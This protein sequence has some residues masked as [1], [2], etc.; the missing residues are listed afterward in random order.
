MA[1]AAMACQVS[2][3]F[4]GTGCQSNCNPPGFQGCSDNQASATH[5]RIGYYEGW[6]LQTSSR[7][8]NAYT[9]EQISAETL[10]HINFAFALI[11]NSFTIIEMTPGDVQLW[12]RTTALKKKNPS[13]KVFLSIGGWSFNDPPT[14]NI[15]SDLVASAANRATFIS[16]ALSVLQAYAFDGIDVDWEYPAAYDRGGNPADKANFVTFMAEVKA[17]FRSNNYGLTFTA[18]SSYWYLQHFDLP[19]L[20]QHADW[21]NIMTYDLHGTWDGKDP[22]IGAIVQAHTNL[23]EIKQTMQLFANVG[24]NPSQMVMGIG[25]YGR[26]FQLADPSCN[27]PGCPFVSGAAPGVCSL[28]SGTLMFSE[29]ESIISSNALTPVFDSIDAV[30]YIVWNDNQWVSYDDSETLQMKLNYANSICLG[31]TM[32]WSVDQDDTS[33][34]ALKGLYP[35]INVN[36]PSFVDATSCMITGCGQGCPSGQQWSAMTTLTTNPGSSVTCP[37]NNPATLCCP[38][39]DKPRNCKWSGGGGTTCNAQCEVGQV[40][41]AIDPVG[42]GK[43]PTCLQGEKAYCCDSNQDLD[44]FA[45]GCGRSLNCA[46]GY[47]ALTTVKQ[48]SSDNGGCEQ[49]NQNLPHPQTCPEVCSTNNKPVCCNNNPGYK[50]C[51]WYG[52][53]PSCTHSACPAGQLA[54]FSD[55]QGD[56]SSPCLGKGKRLFCCDPPNAN[57]FLPVPEDWVFPKFVPGHSEPVNFQP[58]TFTVDF[59]QDTGSDTPPPA[60]SFNDGDENDSPFGEVFISSPNAASVSS[61]DFASDWVVTS[62]DPSSDQPQQVLAYC[63]LPLDH[64]DSGCGHVFIG[65]AKHTIVRMPK[66]CGVGPYARV[67]SLDVHSD[68]NILPDHHAARLPAGEKVYSLSFDYNF[69]A[70]PDENGPVL[71]R[72]DITNMQDYWNEMINS[73]PDSGTDTTRRRRDMK[74]NF[75]Q[76]H[77]YEKRWFGSF[78]SWLNRMNTVK[79]Q[80]SIARTFSWADSY[81]IFHQEESCPNFHSSLDITVAGNAHL[82]SH[83]GYYLEATVVPPA[84][85]QSYVYFSTGAGAQATFTITGLAGVNFDSDKLEVFSAGFPGLYY[86]GLLTL[87]P[88]LHVYVQLTGQLSMSGKFETSI[89]YTFPS[90]DVTIGKEDN[91]A[92]SETFEP[93]V[94]PTSSNQGYNFGFGYNVALEGSAEAHVIPTLQLGLSIL[95]GEL[96][97]AQ[98]FAEADMYVGVGVNGSVSNANAASFCVQPYYGVGVNGG[99]TGSLLWWRDNAVS[100]SFYANKFNFGGHCFSSVTEVDDSASVTKREELHYAEHW[101][102]LSSG[103]PIPILHRSESV[104]YTALESANGSISNIY[105][106]P[107]RERSL[108]PRA[109]VPFLPGNLFCPQDNTGIQGTTDGSDCLFYDDANADFNMGLLTRR[110]LEFNAES[111]LGSTGNNSDS[112]LHFK[113]LDRNPVLTTCPGVTINVPDYNQCPI[114]AYYDLENPTTLDP[115]F[116]S[117]VPKVPV[118]LGTNA[119]GT[120]SLAHP[121]STAIYS[122]EHPYEAQM[123]ATFIDFLQKSTGLWRNAAGNN[124]WCT[125]VNDNLRTTPNYMPAGQNVFTQIGQCYPSNANP[126]AMP[127][128]EQAANV[129]KN[130]ALF[131]GEASLMNANPI[132]VRSLTSFRRYC[133]Q[134]QISVMRATAGVTSFMND[135]TVKN[136][137]LDQNTCIKNVWTTWYGLY[138]TSNVDAPSKNNFDMA[139]LYNTWVFHVVNGVQP[140]LTQQLQT[141]AAN[142]NSANNGAVATVALS[143][144]ILLDQRQTNRNGNPVNVLQYVTPQ[145]QVTQQDV[146]NQ[147]VNSV[148]PIYWASDLLR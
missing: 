88:S 145:M 36:N 23:T 111:Y 31:G 100:T 14:S 60:S 10:T 93:A 4:C 35:D 71:M 3:E 82:S 118:D 114:S 39:G 30:K 96:M 44:C 89:G 48:G 125:W 123:A 131:S 12:L 55:I 11:S 65:Q 129:I 26:S 122:R 59:D 68:Q 8:C 49:Q 7:G 84:I 32:I 110:S 99:L 13:L 47:T 2:V 56:A 66:S 104:A 79:S 113:Q 97:D 101:H 38:T 42:D 109:G 144:P 37:A 52:D 25:F 69:A 127:V 24:I 142:Y 139:S 128:M 137:F 148:Q 126:R 70:I 17:A 20:M 116:G 76:A 94:N 90:F 107:H 86:P 50:N 19:G 77:Q 33:Y 136:F 106:V 58:A 72:A 16:S 81:T 98:V 80:N 45:T 147:I 41:L 108:N 132:P 124:N 120:Q 138:R 18:P 46:A 53:L 5:R 54:V 27:V 62:C 21:V 15:F 112:T 141:M 130:K 34:T 115:T 117:W 9:P 6:A 133:A 146:I 95:G 67:V 75:H 40:T 134:K 91:N 87:G 63:S 103:P 119:D 43:S 73:P 121:G 51:K 1:H 57:Q 135:F 29:I 78:S 28:N 102:S 143:W 61:L 64:E 22:Y 92:D 85:Q 140:F 105:H 74:R 83:F